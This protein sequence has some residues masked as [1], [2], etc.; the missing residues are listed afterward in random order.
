MEGLSYLLNTYFVVKENNSPWLKIEAYNHLHSDVQY[1]CQKTGQ[2][3]LISIFRVWCHSHVSW[4]THYT[5]IHHVVCTV[6][7]G[8]T[9]RTKIVLFCSLYI[10]LIYLSTVYSS[11]IKSFNILWMRVTQRKRKPVCVWMWRCGRMHWGEI[12]P[13]FYIFLIFI[14]K[15]YNKNNKNANW[16][17]HSLTH[18]SM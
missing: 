14:V 12:H 18:C 15:I 1:I 10:Y 13:V 3:T 5:S 11:S 6:G 2:I 9:N 7:E 16:K 17:P 8:T 4:L